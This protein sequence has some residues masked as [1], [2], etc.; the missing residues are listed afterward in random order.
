MLSE[1]KDRHFPPSSINQASEPGLLSL[2]SL[3]GLSIRIIR[4]IRVVNCVVQAGLI[5]QHEEADDSLDDLRLDVFDVDFLGFVRILAVDGSFSFVSASVR[6]IVDG[7][8]EFVR[9]SH[10]KP[11]SDHAFGAIQ[12]FATLAEN[13]L[14]LEVNCLAESLAD[15]T[16]HVFDHLWPSRILPS[17][18]SDGLLRRLV[19]A[20]TD[21]G[22]SERR[23]IHGI[24]EFRFHPK[25]SLSHELVFGLI[26]ECA[27]G[28]K[29][30]KNCAEHGECKADNVRV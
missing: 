10:S 12:I 1:I 21:S 14:A 8:D 29:M 20:A 27:D 7:I 3:I 16:V 4:Q 19:S 26:V 6:D 9:S 24:A 13:L 2:H 11:G 17:W 23:T 25:T 28:W 22:I 18:V 5:R 30:C 15:F